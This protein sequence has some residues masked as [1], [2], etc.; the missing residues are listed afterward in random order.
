M[1]KLVSRGLDIG[2]TQFTNIT[3]KQHDMQVIN[4][5]VAP[6]PVLNSDGPFC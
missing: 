6:F 5:F 4:I 1:P 3:P 2:V